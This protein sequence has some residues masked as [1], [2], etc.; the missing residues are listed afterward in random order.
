MSWQWWTGER[1]GHASFQFCFVFFSSRLLQ[2]VVFFRLVR[3]RLVPGSTSTLKA[4]FTARTRT[5]WSYLISFFPGGCYGQP[6]VSSL[7]FPRYDQNKSKAIVNVRLWTHSEDISSV[8]PLY[9]PDCIINPQF[10]FFFFRLA[11][12]CNCMLL[13][14]I[15]ILRSVLSRAI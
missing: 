15:C 9:R 11:L 4:V 5:T 8:F 3:S 2:F 7:C 13:L 12:V 6:S 14:Y 1:I 10:C